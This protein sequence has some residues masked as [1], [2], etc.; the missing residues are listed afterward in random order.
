[1][2]QSSLIDTAVTPGDR[3]F[4]VVV[5][6]VL[7]GVTLWALP[8]A[9][10]LL[11]ASPA[12]M[13]MFAGI[14]A[15]A[16]FLT[17][18]LL[19]SQGS[20]TASARILFLGA[21]Y[22]FCGLIIIPHLLTFPGVFDPGLMMHHTADA[23]V[24]LWVFWHAGFGI[25]VLVFCLWPWNAT[26]VRHP[27]R[28]LARATLATL[29]ITAI[30]AG[31]GLFAP[32]PSLLHQD[33]YSAMDTLG[34]TG[35]LVALEGLALLVALIRLR[36]RTLLEQWL[37]VAALEF[38]LD[39]TLTLHGSTR[40]SLGWYVAR[41][42]S[43][44]ASTVVLSAFLYQLG[45]LYNELA[46]KKA[47]LDE[48]HAQQRSLNRALSHQAQEDLLTGLFNRRG[49]ETLL[50]GEWRRWERYQRSF[51]VLMLD[52]D[53]F[54]SINDNYGHAVGDAVLQE[55][56]Q[57]LRKSLRAVDLASRYG[58]EEFLVLMPETQRPGAIQAA[59]TL[60]QRLA[61]NP[62]TSHQLTVTASIGVAWAGAY[63]D[64]ESL[65]NAADSA[66]YRAK[67]AGRNRVAQA[68]AD[69]PHPSPPKSVEAASA[70]A[71]APLPTKTAP[72]TKT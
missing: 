68:T 60:C 40:Y 52:L 23:A 30:V 65:L 45:Q 9:T 42:N 1:M 59:E 31:V 56:G 10:R 46:H 66:C 11:P 70:P 34:I 36:G 32:L 4:A 25:G 48:A 28:A 67:Q 22:L 8:H 58:G 71:L 12:F 49:I 53:H 19:L 64:L 26:P 39:V 6:T 44:A 17:A 63:P 37:T 61:A 33:N 20:M 7:A 72:A 5:A 18:Y 47:E 35:A 41:L 38:L 2:A 24:W 16:D 14:M 51:S 29:L 62:L 43:M 54:K 3:R 27:R 69:D 15:F 55:L 21:V 57:L 50:A 13:P